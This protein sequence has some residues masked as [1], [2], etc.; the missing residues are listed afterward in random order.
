MIFK[1]PTFARPARSKGRVPSTFVGGLAALRGLLALLLLACED[2]VPDNPFVGDPPNLLQGTI[3]AGAVEEPATSVVF[4]SDA[5]NPPP[6]LGTG[7][8]ATFVGVGADRFTSDGSGLRA[9]PFTVDGVPDGAWVLTGLMDHDGDF[10]PSVPTLAGATCGDRS[11]AWISAS[12]LPAPV[13]VAGGQ[14]VG[15]LTVTLGGPLS[16]ERP[17]FTIDDGPALVPGLP[18]P[19]V[20]SSVGV[21]ATYGPELSLTLAPPSDP[22]AACESSFLLHF[23]DLNRDGVIDARADV[24]PE[25]GL[26][27]VWP[28]IYVE[29]LGAPG[30]GDGDGLTDTFTRDDD[31]ARYVTEAI[32]YTPCGAP[33][34]TPPEAAAIGVPTR[35]TRLPALLLPAVVR[36]DTSG[37]TPVATDDVP[38]GAWSVTVV[39]ETGQTWTVPNELDT[40]L[41]F[42]L[43]SPGVTSPRDPSQGRWLQVRD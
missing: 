12:G 31:G 38:P 5:D 7:R 30:D 39:L 35:V 9:A 26:L 36:I 23:R 28:R 32:P 20:L 42:A 33:G 34:C 24:P 18:Q 1:V 10:H 40:A 8:P 41:P 19:F 37:T 29:W 27:D 16:T 11:G 6:P 25:S 3:L 43:P 22:L 2:E 14:R 15:A 21:E 4:V 17:A 13:E